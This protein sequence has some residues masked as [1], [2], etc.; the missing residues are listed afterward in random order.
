MVNP[1]VARL[2]P[3]M[4]KLNERMA[5]PGTSVEKTAEDNR[6]EPVWKMYNRLQEIRDI[7]TEE[8]HN[9]GA[10]DWR[11]LKGACKR[12]GKV[13]F[14]NLDERIDEICNTLVAMDLIVP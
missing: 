5:G 3:V 9:F 13:S 8:G 6:L 12:I 10:S 2:N 1:T 11:K 4:A 14:D 7:M